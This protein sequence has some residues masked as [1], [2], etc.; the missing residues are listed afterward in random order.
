[1][2]RVPYSIFKV[3]IFHLQIAMM[4]S[5]CS[6]LLGLTPGYPVPMV[7]QPPIEGSGNGDSEDP[8]T[9]D[10]HDHTFCVDV[11]AWGPIEWIGKTIEKCNTTFVK[12][13]KDKWKT[14]RQLEK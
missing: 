14:V 1:M 2:S 3:N 10:L 7:Y 4:C 6:A 8:G 9:P 13:R 11:S 12:E 5:G